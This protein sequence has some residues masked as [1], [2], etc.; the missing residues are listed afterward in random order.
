[1][2]NNILKFWIK[3]VPYET[4]F[5]CRWHLSCKFE[6]LFS[7]LADHLPTC[8][9]TN[10]MSL[11]LSFPSLWRTSFLPLTFTHL[12]QT[13]GHRFST[14]TAIEAGGCS[15]LYLSEQVTPLTHLICH[16]VEPA[17]GLWSCYNL[18]S[19]YNFPGVQ[20]AKQVPSKEYWTPICTGSDTCS[21]SL[22]SFFGEGEFLPQKLPC[23]L[24][25]C[26]S[27]YIWPFC[28]FRLFWFLFLSI[29][30]QCKDLWAVW[31]QGPHLCCS[32]WSPQHLEQCLT[33][34]TDSL[35]D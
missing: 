25:W 1:M 13:V 24:G 7:W 9:S 22:S 28:N 8:C 34:D 17:L 15:F 19:C 27:F 10:R 4:G 6:L 12:V 31:V 33:G 32:L 20:T 35:L 5:L 26:L 3:R 14:G 30:K 21:E 29:Q 16:C 18:S 2:G 23:A 11:R